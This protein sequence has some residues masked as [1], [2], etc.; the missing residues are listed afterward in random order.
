MKQIIFILKIV[1]GKSAAAPAA[2]A[3]PAV[4]AGRAT[5]RPKMRPKMKNA[6]AVGTILEHISDYKGDF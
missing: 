3:A 1:L 4:A 6:A 2:P 5:N